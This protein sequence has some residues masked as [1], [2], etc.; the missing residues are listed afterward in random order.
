MDQT[1]S[2]SDSKPSDAKV[3]PIPMHNG[4][5]LK[6]LGPVLPLSQHPLRKLKNYQQ[7]QW[8]QRK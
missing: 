1:P 7:N 6:S 3:K 5:E 2:T 8:S 4:I